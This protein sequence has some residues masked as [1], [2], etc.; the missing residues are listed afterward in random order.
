MSEDSKVVDPNHSD[1]METDDFVPRSSLT[2]PAYKLSVCLI[3]TYKN[4]NKVYYEAKAK[5]QIDDT[6]SRGGV[7]NGGYDDQHY[8]YIV[9]HEELVADRY[10]LKHRIGKVWSFCRFV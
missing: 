8:D 9:K 10:V 3:D 6:D 7:H 2:R 5:R 1:A 4:I